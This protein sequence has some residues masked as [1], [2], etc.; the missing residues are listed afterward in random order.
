MKRRIPTAAEIVVHTDGVLAHRDGHQFVLGEHVKVDVLAVAIV[1][2]A[3]GG[4]TYAITPIAFACA[5]AAIASPAR[6]T[7]LVRTSPLTQVP[8]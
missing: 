4:E 7:R 5:G 6:T 8:V 2:R 3:V 1:D